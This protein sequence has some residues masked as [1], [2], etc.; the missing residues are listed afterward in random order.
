MCGVIHRNLG[1]GAAARPRCIPHAGGAPSA[2]SLIAPQKRPPF[3]PFRRRRSCPSRNPPRPSASP[4]DHDQEETS[5]S[6][7]PH[8]PKAC[9]ALGTLHQAHRTWTR[10]RAFEPWTLILPDGQPSRRIGCAHE[11]SALRS[12]FTRTVKAVR[13]APTMPPFRAV[14]LRLAAF[15]SFGPATSLRASRDPRVP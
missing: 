6:P 11:P 8:R 12:A 13:A 7:G 15:R 10:P 14:P 4:L 2:S 5:L 9:A 3:H 1:K